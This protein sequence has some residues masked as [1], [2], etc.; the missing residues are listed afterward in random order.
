[1]GLIKKY[2][3][4]NN[5]CNVTFSLPK[6]AVNAAKNVHLVGE[7]NEWQKERTPMIRSKDGSIKVALELKSGREYQ[8]RYLIDG[9]TWENDFQADKYVPSPYGAFDNSV[10]IV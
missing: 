8:Y 5:T 3:K 10:V 9:K 4:G 2:A 1:M 7:F 6:E